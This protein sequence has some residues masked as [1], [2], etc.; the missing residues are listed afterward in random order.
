MFENLQKKMEGAAKQLLNTLSCISSI[1][2][3]TDL[4]KLDREISNYIKFIPKKDDG[5]LYGKIIDSLF[6]LIDN[7]PQTI[8]DSLAKLI[9]K[10]M[11]TSFPIFSMLHELL[12]SSSDCLKKSANNCTIVFLSSTL[13]KIMQSDALYYAIIDVCHSNEEN[14]I[15]KSESDENWREFLQ[16]LVSLPSKIAN[17]LKGKI[18]GTFSPVTYCQIIS[19]HI[20]RSIIHLN[21]EFPGQSQINLIS[22]LISK[23]ILTLGSDKFKY[24]IEILIFWSSANEKNSRECLQNILSNLDRPAVEPIAIFL[25]KSPQ[26]A[27]Y[28]FQILENLLNYPEWTFVLLKKIPLL[29]YYNSD[30]LIIN[31]ISFLG[32]SVNSEKKFVELLINLLDIWGDRSALAHTSLEQQEYIT[33]LILLSVKILKNKLKS[34]EKDTVQR[35]LF[36]GTSAHLES[37]QIEVRVIG[38]I[39][40]ELIVEYLNEG[41]DAPKLQYE[42]D[43]MPESGQK[44]VNNIKKFV[45]KNFEESSLNCFENFEDKINELGIKCA[46]LPEIESKNA[47]K[48]SID[49]HKVTQ[50][51]TTSEITDGISKINLKTTDSD[52]LD[53]DDDL[54]PFDMSNDTKIIEKLRPI[55]LRDLK[56]NLLNPN[57]NNKDPEIFSE[58]LA[59][60]EELILSQL[61]HDDPSLGLELLEII[62]SLQE[63]I[64]VENFQLLKFNSCVAIVTVFPKYCAEKLCSEFHAKIGTHS[65]NDRLFFLDVLCESAK[66]LS[67]VEFPDEKKILK[68]SETSLSISK[69]KL[70]KP[71]SLFIDVSGGKKYET[72]Y[73]EDFEVSAIDDNTHNKKHSDWQA[74]VEQRIQSNTRHFAHESKRPKVTKNKFNNSV[75]Y[76]FYP[77]LYG[78]CQKGT[79]LYKIPNSFVDHENILLVHFLK[80]L[81]T[82]MVAAENCT[83]VEKM[84]LDIL[85]LA[86]NLRYHEQAKI[87]LSVIEN[88]ASVIVALGEDNF[89]T[90]IV[91][92][93]LEFRKW[94]FDVSQDSFRGD[95]DKNCRSLGRNVLAL[96]DSVIKSTISCEK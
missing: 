7:T 34:S 72:L 25:L 67:K 38:M 35:L 59:A 50:P 75:K 44:I 27:K 15:K 48:N 9:E 22:S 14:Y 70:H 1:K 47:T 16:N 43:S 92:L 10:V 88:I 85:E 20:A 41:V 17:K 29:S 84:A 69:V 56:E 89:T 63:T 42:Y 31:L 52:D 40:G 18:P 11:L 91:E 46:I 62:M 66:K 55:Y 71:I 65:I 6:L 93:L 58:S 61:P 12:I 82:I 95:P 94:L 37:M 3:Q 32:L 49:S 24:L 30:I 33:K 8:D 81:S 80:T 2:S 26:N 19:Y 87:R 68:N 57:Q 76:F 64:S 96:I 86:W 45:D 36:S 74:V 54:L 28:I 60:A 21:K 39:T 90:E 23:L 4:H 51:S 53:S 77:L 83:L 78:L 5:F 79:C 73:D 13:A